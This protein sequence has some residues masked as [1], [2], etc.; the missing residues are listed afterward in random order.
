MNEP[1]IWEGVDIALLVSSPIFL[2]AGIYWVG[3]YDI[4]GSIRM[5]AH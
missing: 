4:I 2:V 5:E 3:Y 1:S